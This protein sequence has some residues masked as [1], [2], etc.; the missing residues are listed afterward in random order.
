LAEPITLTG[1]DFS[2]LEVCAVATG[3][4]VL[5]H[6]DAVAMMARTSKIIIE[7]AASGQAIY[8]VTTGLGPR[9]SEALA[10]EEIEAFALNTVRGRAH[11]VGEP[12]SR[13]VAHW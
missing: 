6:T 7:A 11:S 8:G 10:A 4:R 13:P 5:M 12:L 3:R 1:K 2:V 9:V